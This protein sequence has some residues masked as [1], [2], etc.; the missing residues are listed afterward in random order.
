MK[1]IIGGDSAGG[2]L[3]LGLL[4]M[5]RDE[6]P[7]LLPAGAVPLSPWCDLTQGGETFIKNAE[8]GV[9]NCDKVRHRAAT[10][11]TLPRTART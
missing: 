1:V 3:I 10:L 6:S 11:L 7:E 9:A 4:L 5:L 2:G 8:S